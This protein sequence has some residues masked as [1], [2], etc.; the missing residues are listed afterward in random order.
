MK[1]TIFA[2]LTLTLLFLAGCGEEVEVNEPIKKPTNF[3]ECVAAGY[4]ILESY[5]AQCRTEDSSFTQDVPPDNAY[6]CSD[7]QKQAE[8]CTLEYAPVCGDDQTTYGNDCGACSSGNIDYYTEGE[9][10][11]LVKEDS[12]YCVAPPI[13]D[14]DCEDEY[15]PVCAYDELKNQIGT[16]SNDC[17]ACQNED[18]LYYING[19]CV[20]EI[21]Y[22]L[23]VANF[24]SEQE[25]EV[26]ISADNTLLQT[27][28]LEPS[29]NTVGTPSI[30]VLTISIPINTLELTATELNNGFSESLTLD[31]NGGNY[32]K[33]SYGIPGSVAQGK[34]ITIYQLDEQVMYD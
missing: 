27:V 34:Y 9:C 14:F 29:D 28:V 8:I 25:I 10:E 6:I 17:V 12:H 33:I 32:I 23:T 5:P 15:D 11:E 7:E 20:E 13:E 24:D 30:E 2:L 16:I 4:P 18:V 31:H 19:E 3:E 26:E 1:K 21:E 22:E